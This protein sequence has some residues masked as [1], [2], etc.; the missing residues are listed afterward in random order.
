[1][2]RILTVEDIVRIPP[3]SF[4]NPIDKAATDQVKLKYENIV[5]EQLGY[6]VS[7]LMSTWTR[8]VRYSR[9]TGRHIIE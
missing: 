3:K 5:D 8:W 6:A 2:F 7:W 4:G 9:E 1:M